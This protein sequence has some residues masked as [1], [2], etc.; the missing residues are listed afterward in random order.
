MRVKKYSCIV[1]TG[2]AEEIS[3]GGSYKRRGAF[4]LYIAYLTCHAAT[5]KGDAEQTIR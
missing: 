4:A 1:R 5:V 3:F 2:V